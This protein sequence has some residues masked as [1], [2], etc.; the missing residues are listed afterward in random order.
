MAKK[1]IILERLPS[2]R[3]SYRYAMWVDV[4]LSQQVRYADPDKESRYADITADELALLRT[5]EVLEVVETFE[6]ETGTTLAQIIAMLEARWT[7]LQS[8][9]TNQKVWD[10]YGTSWDGDTWD[11]V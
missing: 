11:V 3:I 5:G 4:P 2:E 7:Q 6:R 10:R 8:Q 1:I 9:I